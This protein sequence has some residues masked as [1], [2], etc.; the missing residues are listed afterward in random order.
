MPEGCVL[1]VTRKCRKQKRAAKMLQA[2]S[3][4]CLQGSVP[5]DVTTQGRIQ[6]SKKRRVWKGWGA[7]LR[8]ED[9]GF[10]VESVGFRVC[11]LGFRGW[12]GG[13]WFEVR[14]WGLECRLL[15]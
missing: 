11:G 10:R 4:G 7:G 2:C 12:A 14:G 5:E 6:R 3:L 13:L 8:V 1:H 15:G 9:S